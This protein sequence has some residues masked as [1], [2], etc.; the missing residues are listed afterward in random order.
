MY[1][2]S[3]PHHR[4][5]KE[6]LPHERET[7]LVVKGGL[8]EVLIRQLGLCHKSSDWSAANLYRQMFCLNMALIIGWETVNYVQTNDF[9]FVYLLASQRNA[10]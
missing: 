6:T 2:Y 8:W 1:A 4:Y 7:L 9:L 3:L 10:C 5:L